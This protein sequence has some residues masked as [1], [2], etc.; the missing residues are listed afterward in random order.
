MKAVFLSTSIPEPG[1]EY[2]GTTNPLLIQAAVR[3]LAVLL[4][5]RRRIVW[6]GH[7]SI[8]PMI[9]AACDGLGVEYQSVVTLYQ[10]RAFQKDFPKENRHFAN[11]E[12]VD[13]EA[14]V[15]A[16]LTA[17]RTRV[18]SDFAFDGGVFIGGMNGIIDEHDMF[19][20]AHPKAKVVVVSSP[21]GAAADLAKRYLYDASTDPSPTNF[22]KLFVE[23]LGVSL[24]EPRHVT[25]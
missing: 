23:R 15:E 18:F 17:L 13:A 6:G 5:G 14:T 10:S 3:A 21:G 25:R 11:V 16:S 22:T 8:T 19:V 9:V 4:L 7:P 20:A 24:A 2:Y 1:R 12:L